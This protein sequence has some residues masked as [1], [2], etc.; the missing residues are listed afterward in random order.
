MRKIVAIPI[1][2]YLLISLPTGKIFAFQS[3]ILAT[4][5]TLRR[6]PSTF[7]NLLSKFRSS[8]TF[9]SMNEMKTQV[10]NNDNLLHCQQ[11]SYLREG[12]SKVLRCDKKPGSE[13]YLVVLDNS[14][15]YPEG[16]GKNPSSL[17]RFI[18][19]VLQRS[20]LRLRYSEW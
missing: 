1:L 18:D 17:H 3:R 16:G 4:T 11:N 9:V 2:F 12:V 19:R 8:Q 14:V 6:S 5:Q 20:T 10:L 7:S 13:S 15:L